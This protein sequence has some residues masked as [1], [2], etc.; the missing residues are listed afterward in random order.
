MT[1][2]MSRER[3]DLRRTDMSP[4]FWVVM[5]KPCCAPV[6]RDQ[7]ATS[8]VLAR[9]VSI[10]PATALVF[11]QGGAGG[12]LI[13]QDE[14][15]LVELRE[16]AGLQAVAQQPRAERQRQEQQNDDQRDAPGTSRS[17]RA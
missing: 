14:A 5:S 17:S 10:C 7:A 16:E 11:G 8:G 4:T 3:W 1:A 2:W 6:W 15:A 12:E 9:T 13:I